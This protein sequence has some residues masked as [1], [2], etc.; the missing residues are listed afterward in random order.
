MSVTDDRERVLGV[1]PLRKSK[2]LGR[3][4]TFAAVL[5]TSRMIFAQITGEM[6]KEAVEKAKNQAK[7]EGKGFL[8]QWAAQLGATLSYAN[9]Y[10]EMTPSQILSETPGNFAIG[11]DAI[12]EIK[13]KPAS[14]TAEEFNVEIDSS[15]GKLVFRMDGS[16]EKVELLKQ[17]YGDRVKLPFGYSISGLSLG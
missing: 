1:L 6:V 2:S 4:D 16:A 5:T 9:R 7:S 15:S 13:I 10:L 3:W 11:N 12:R 14:G 17:V 8:G